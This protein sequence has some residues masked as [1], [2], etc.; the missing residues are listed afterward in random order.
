[1]GDKD[2][3]APHGDERLQ[4][5]CWVYRFY[6]SADALLY[7]G[8]AK[9]LI[10]RLR[11][12]AVCGGRFAPWTREAVGFTVRWYPTR[13][14]AELVEAM[15]IAF[16]SPLHNSTRPVGRAARTLF[17]DCALEDP[18]ARRLRLQTELREAS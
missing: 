6:D 18:R 11:E 15:A 3:L 1:M 10:T 2:W 16:E 8:V 9:T 13:P 4:G 5:P 14:Q 17:G 7:V 12:H